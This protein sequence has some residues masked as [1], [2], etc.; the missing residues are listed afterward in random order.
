MGTLNRQITLACRPVGLPTESDFRL[1]ESPIPA[2][3]DGQMLVKTRVLSVDPYM[4]GMISDRKSYAEPVRIGDIMI[5]EAVGSVVSSRSSGFREGDVVAGMFGWQEFALVDDRQVRPIDPD[6]AAIS[7]ALHVLGMPGLTA[8]FGLLDVCKLREGE[9]V[10]V[11]GAAGAVGSIAGQIAKI[12]GCRVVGTAGSTAKIDHII[13]DL[14]FD[15]GLNYKTTDDYG[16]A[17]KELCPDGIDVYFDNV[18]GRLTDAVV[19]QLNVHA[20]VGICG[21]ISQYNLERPEQGPRWLWQLIVKRARVEGFLITDYTERYHEGLMAL[22]EWLDGGQLKYR[23]TIVNGIEN[24]PSAF[25]GMLQGANIG[26]QLVKVA[27]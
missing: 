6:L 5:G 12:R 8:Y 16:R 21:Q 20:R 4:R 24:A 10:L 14:G 27:E 7:T 18:G 22:S 1:V 9:Q 13:N 19:R 25:I 3:L 17:L 23:E 2:P 11:S 26:K 15:A